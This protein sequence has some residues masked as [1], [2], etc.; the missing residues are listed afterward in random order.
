MA[1]AD[2]ETFQLTRFVAPSCVQP[3]FS[4]VVELLVGNESKRG[5]ISWSFKVITL[6]SVVVLLALG[7]LA[8]PAFSA[9]HYVNVP[10]GDVEALKSALVQAQARQADTWIVL[11]GGT[12]LFNAD[13]QLPEVRATVSIHSWQEPA[14][15]QG[16][17]GGPDN[18]FQVHQ[19][20]T[21]ILNNVSFQG[22]DPQLGAGLADAGLVVNRGTLQMHE[23]QFRDNVATLDCSAGP[24]SPFKPLVLNQ[25]SG[26]FQ[27]QRVSVVNSG[28]KAP[29]ADANQSAG[30][31]LTNHGS[32]RF[33]VTQLYLGEPGFAPALKN[34]GDMRL[35]NVTFKA[36]VTHGEPRRE[37]I[38]SSGVYR[39]ANSIID[40]FGSDW[41]ETVSSDGY[42]L[43]DNT[44]CSI[45]ANSDIVGLPT[46]LRWQ[47]VESRWQGGPLQILTHALVP[48]AASPAV[49][50][51]ND[52][53]C[54]AVSIE[55]GMTFRDDPR[56]LDG[57][58]DGVSSCDRGAV[59]VQSNFVA[60]GGINGLYYSPDADGHYVYVADTA[61]NTMVMWTTFDSRGQPA[62]IFGIANE[63]VAGRSIIAEAYI[64]RDGLVSASGQFDP[65]TSEPWGYLELDM[66]DCEFGTFAFHSETPGFGSGQIEVRRLANLKR[67]DCEPG[68]PTELEPYVATGNVTALIAAIE[69]ANQQPP[70]QPVTIQVNGTYVFAYE[71]WLPPITGNLT[72]RGGGPGAILTSAHW[73]PH[74][75]VQPGAHLR[76]ENI[77]FA[78]MVLDGDM[79]INAGT[80]ELDRVQ[81][82]RVQARPFCTRFFCRDLGRIIRNDASG[83]AW[84]DRV[85][86]VDSGGSVH[87]SYPGALIHNSGIA[88]VLNSQI[89]YPFGLGEAP[90][91]NLNQLSIH[92]TT[93]SGQQPGIHRL[94]V[95][96]EFGEGIGQ[97]EISNSVVS[98]FDTAWCQHAVSGGYNLVDSPECGFDA[99]GDL[100]G[101]DPGLIWAPV[102]ADWSAGGR[103]I[104]DKALV[105]KAKS[106]AIDSGSPGSCNDGGL[107]SEIRNSLDGDGD[108]S[109]QCDRGA[110][111]RIPSTL[112]QGG[113]N[114]LYFNSEAD[115]HYLYVAETEFAV[116]VMWTTFDANGDQAWIFGIA[117]R[118][119][120]NGRVLAQAYINRNGKVRLDGKV[121][122]AESEPWGT[123]DLRMNSCGR[124]KLIYQSDQPGFGSGEFQFERLAE[125]DQVGCVD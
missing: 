46:G 69:T 60:D 42:N 38:E 95:G 8:R 94:L 57:D 115:G 49:D 61:F 55:D 91:F 81:I 5:S 85:S 114:G 25:A 74:F 89:Y 62:W 73:R 96:N 24:C 71:Q 99:E 31:V 23:T 15:F 70:D 72:I 28:V 109:A 64:N 107:V 78:D 120:P 67:L 75:E 82:T 56:S 30:A 97:L 33:L 2:A 124:G 123:L 6:R 103:Q 40:G 9:D 112:T 59:E 76:L 13:D 50:S 80:L 83:T 117:D 119:R 27:A 58:H 12:Y 66:H 110:V 111:E 7:L 32:S 52:D 4:Q 68:K 44:E 1:A 20:G 116:M 39:L 53:W 54:P 77:E 104:L 84:L 108:G 102:E 14:Y 36:P 17:D 121:F 19:Q 88:R 98:G 51:A 3:A 118:V 45:A 11:V 48:I 21:L 41:C 26:Y 79:I 16:L 92:N 86:V 47:A 10:D 100:V 63:S 87:W 125:V 106:L 35:R 29:T 65:A 90:F 18:L 105:P 93:M 34:T 113:L 37:F 122:P 101:H 22:F 43:V